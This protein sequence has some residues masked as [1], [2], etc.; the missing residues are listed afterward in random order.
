MTNSQA[1]DYTSHEF[2][3]DSS[4]EV[5]EIT[6]RN[7]S[8]VSLESVNIAGKKVTLK[9]KP[10]TSAAG[11]GSITLTFDAEATDGA[12]A[13]NEKALSIM[14][15][16]KYRMEVWGIGEA[17]DWSGELNL[18]LEDDGELMLN[19]IGVLTAEQKLA[20]VADYKNKL[21]NFPA[22]I[23]V[24]AKFTGLLEAMPNDLNVSVGWN[25]EVSAQVS[26]DLVSHDRFDVN[27]GAGFSGMY[28]DGNEGNITLDLEATAEWSLIPKRLSI[29]AGYIYKN[30]LGLFP[31]P[32]SSQIGAEGKWKL[33]LEYNF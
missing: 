5:S 31:L 19:G 10:A 15:T 1:S 11:T 20:A 21:G 13:D 16:R 6:L 2:S 30:K 9:T 18:R 14:A 24:L 4:K 7:N 29:E 23:D 17:N 27:L 33:S 12:T 25:A 3:W 8:W 28:Q 32:P 22:S 26:Y